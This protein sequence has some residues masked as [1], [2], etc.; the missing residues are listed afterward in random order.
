MNSYVRKWQDLRA[1]VAGGAGEQCDRA[2]PAGARRPQGR[3]GR[4][5]RSR[6]G[7]RSGREQN[8]GPPQYLRTNI[9]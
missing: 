2:R 3:C 4:P 5:Q 1:A 9:E 6:P 8:V 7:P